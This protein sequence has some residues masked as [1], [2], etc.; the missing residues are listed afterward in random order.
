[1]RLPFRRPPGL[2]VAAS[3]A[4]AA[5]C[6]HAAPSPARWAGANSTGD[7]AFVVGEVRSSW[8]GRPVESTRLRLLDPNGNPHDSAST[9][10]AGAFV[11]GPVPPGAYRL[12]ARAMLHRPLARLLALRAGSVDTVRLRLTYDEA[13]A[14]IDCV[15]PERPDG[16]RGFGSQFCRP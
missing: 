14:I 1:M 5:A 4:V 7:V 8:R 12:Q 9:D 3:V 11:L 2:L 15:G 13:G 16:S 6:R 10:A